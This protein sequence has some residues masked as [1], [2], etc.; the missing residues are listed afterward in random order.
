MPKSRNRKKKN[1]LHAKSKYCSLKKIVSQISYCRN[2]FNEIIY[3]EK[4]ELPFPL[5]ISFNAIEEN[6]NDFF[7]FCKKCNEYSKVS[8][9]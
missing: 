4:D 1:T 3:Y 8:L 9:S 2:C 7:I 5:Q 6:S